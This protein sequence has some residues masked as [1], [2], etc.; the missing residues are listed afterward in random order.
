M[1]PQNI[2]YTRLAFSWDSSKSNELNRTNANIANTAE[3]VELMDA[4]GLRD[5]MILVCGGPRITHELAK[6]LMAKAE[7]KGVKFLIPVDSVCAPEFKNDSPSVTC[8]ADEM[9]ADMV[10]IEEAE[11]E[12]A[13]SLVENHTTATN[14][15]DIV[16]VDAQTTEADDTE[17]PTDE[18]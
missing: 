13:E 7:E 16:S 14:S 15:E 9:P 17:T 3:L 2:V 8:S 5:K 12:L 10:E 1:R 6:E 4:E 11:E 18:I